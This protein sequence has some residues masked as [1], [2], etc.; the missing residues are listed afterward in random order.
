[1]LNK[2]M[3]MDWRQKIMELKDYINTNFPELILKPSLYEQWNKSIHFDLVKGMY[4]FKD[5]ADETKS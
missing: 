1:M 5:D 4:Q 3:K 2:R